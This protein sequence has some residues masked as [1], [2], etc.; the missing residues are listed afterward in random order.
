MMNSSKKTYIAN[1]AFNGEFNI[2]L[3]IIFETE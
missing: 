3:S 1:G 2:I